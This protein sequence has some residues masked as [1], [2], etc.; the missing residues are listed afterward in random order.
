MTARALGALALLTG[1]A[2]SLV[3]THDA[4]H[5]EQAYLQ[6]PLGAA[7]YVV[8]GL[9]ILGY[10]YARG[11]RR[12][13]WTGGW[14]FVLTCLALYAVAV[15]LNIGAVNDTDPD[16]PVMSSLI[17]LMLLPV[18]LALIAGGVALR[19]RSDR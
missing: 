13:L 8:M 5:A 7:L 19:S 2:V 6:A 18:A 11:R 4:A 16:D 1:S 17:D 14:V 15:V 9:A 10:G 12:A 3:G